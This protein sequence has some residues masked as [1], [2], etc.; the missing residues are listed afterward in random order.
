MVDL[1]L[2][3]DAYKKKEVSIFASGELVAGDAG[4]I[5]HLPKASLVKTVDVVNLDTNATGG[6]ATVAGA[7]TDNFYPTGSDVS[8]S[9]V[10]GRVRVVISY[11]E[12]DLAKGTQTD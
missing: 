6:T 12:L 4:V 10:S 1:T 8:V 9:G 11:F 5:L 2:K 3:G 7:A